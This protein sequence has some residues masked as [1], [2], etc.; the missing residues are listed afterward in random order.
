LVILHHL[1]VARPVQIECDGI[2]KSMGEQHHEAE[3]DRNESAFR[4]LFMTF[5]P[6]VKAML[7]RQGTDEDA[8][9]EIAQDAILAAWRKLHQFSSDKGSVSGWIYAIA[10]NLRIERVHKKAAWQRFDAEFETMELLQSSAG[11]SPSSQWDRSDIEKALKK[12]PPEQLQIIRLSFVDGLTQSEIAAG[13][14]LPLGTVKSRMR[15]AFEKLRCTTE[16]DA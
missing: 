6:K 2:E 10:R 12:L 16:R 8:A 1:T 5:Y 14:S 15:L 4:S 9:E 3:D 11:Q 13:L 7:L